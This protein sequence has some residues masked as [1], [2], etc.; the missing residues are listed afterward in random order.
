[1]KLSNTP[2]FFMISCMALFTTH[3]YLCHYKLLHH[4]MWKKLM[5]FWLSMKDFVIVMGTKSNKPYNNDSQYQI[6]IC[7]KKLM[8]FCHVNKVNQPCNIVVQYQ[9]TICEQNLMIFCHVNKVNQ[10]CN[11]VSQYQITICEQKLMIFVM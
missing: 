4:I 1:M 9:I 2:A 8:I 3:H 6:T 11:H 7:D 10:T 5:S